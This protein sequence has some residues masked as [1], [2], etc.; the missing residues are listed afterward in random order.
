LYFKPW[1][2]T[3]NLPPG[4]NVLTAIAT[5]SSGATTTSAPI[6]VFVEEPP[7]IPAMIA[8]VTRTGTA[9]IITAQAPGEMQYV[10]EASPD[11]TNWIT[12]DTQSAFE[13]SV[14]FSHESA[15]EIQFYRVRTL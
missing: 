10:L 3:T 15:E 1:L 5:D 4:T 2:V 7:L 8:T 13:G 14:T 6:T 12:V 9:T 11:L